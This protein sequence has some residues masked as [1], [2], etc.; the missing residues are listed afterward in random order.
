MQGKEN[1]CILAEEEQ[2]INHPTNSTLSRQKVRE[3]NEAGAMVELVLLSFSLD[4]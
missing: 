2:D 1:F 3:R 4:E